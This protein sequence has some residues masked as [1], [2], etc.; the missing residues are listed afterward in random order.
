[1]K[2]FLQRI[3]AWWNRRIVP[4]RNNQSGRLLPNVKCR[5]HES[6]RLSGDLFFIRISLD[7]KRDQSPH[8]WTIQTIAGCSPRRINENGAVHYLLTFTAPHK[9]KKVDIQFQED[10]NTYFIH[11][12]TWSSILPAHCAIERQYQWVSSMPQVP[13]PMPDFARWTQPLLS[14]IIPVFHPN[15]EHF[16]RCVQSVLNQEWPVCSYEIILQLDGPHPNRHELCDSFK[17]MNHIRVEQS[18]THEGIALCTNRALSR[19]CGS[20]CLFLDQDDELAP[21]CFHLF[22][23]SIEDGVSVYYADEV[24]IDDKGAFLRPYY[25][26]KFDTAY[27]T[28]INYINHPVFVLRQAGETIQWH[29]EGV[30]GAQDHDLLLRLARKGYLFK[31]IPH[32]MYYWRATPTSAAHS[33]KSKPYAWEQ[34]VEVIKDYYKEE[35]IPFEVK[36]GPWFGTYFHLPKSSNGAVE[37]I[38][39][40]EVD[41]DR[42]EID[43]TLQA[44]NTMGQ[45]EQEAHHRADNVEEWI[46]MVIDQADAWDCQ[47]VGFIKKGATSLTD[48]WVTYVNRAFLLDDLGVMATKTVDAHHRLLYAGQFV[49]SEAMCL[50]D[51]LRG[52]K[53]AHPGY[54]R[55]DLTRTLSSCRMNGSFVRS[56]TL[57]MFVQQGQIPQLNADTMMWSLCQYAIDKGLSIRYI[58][59]VSWLLTDLNAHDQLHEVRLADIARRSLR[60][61]PYYPE[62]LSTSTDKLLIRALES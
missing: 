25:K 57:S 17:S 24:K 28:S 14:V 55:K 29:R 13:I 48:H 38:M 7:V 26:P 33:E 8:A 31:H 1:M 52:M 43:C 23:S 50:R 4:I 10:R 18:D 36:K 3:L 46:V 6:L 59:Y 16:N 51:C 49:D 21:G 19:A 22:A 61:D 30:D 11:V 62:E 39:L 5:I 32:V 15:V 47:I 58:P 42:R 34:G 27:L 2:A 20:Y 54:I 40:A 60:R 37:R 44:L 53:D 12:N 45:V 56:S 41:D 35:K 9:P